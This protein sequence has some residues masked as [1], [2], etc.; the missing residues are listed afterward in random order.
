MVDGKKMALFDEGIGYHAC[1]ITFTLLFLIKSGA[2][3]WWG[4]L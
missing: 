3:G 4:L 1:L 2:P